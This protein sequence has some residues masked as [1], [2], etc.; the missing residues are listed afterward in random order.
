[1]FLK[2]VQFQ[3]LSDKLIKPNTMTRRRTRQ[4]RGR[5]AACAVQNMPPDPVSRSQ[6]STASD[7][8]TEED[9]V[10]V[11]TEGSLKPADAMDMQK[12]ST[13]PTEMA[14]ITEHSCHTE[15]KNSK[16]MEEQRDGN[17][18]IAVIAGEAT[19]LEGEGFPPETEQ[20]DKII[21]DEKMKDEM[22]DVSDSHIFVGDER[23]GK[24]LKVKKAVEEGICQSGKHLNMPSTTEEEAISHETDFSEE[25][26]K[27]EAQ[28]KTYFKEEKELAVQEI[29]D[30]EVEALDNKQVTGEGKEPDRSE[31]SLHRED[32]LTDRDEFSVCAFEREEKTCHTFDSS[33]VFEGDGDLD[34]GDVEEGDDDDE[35]GA[36]ILNSMEW[37][38]ELWKMKKA[39][40]AKA[41]GS[42]KVEN[43]DHDHQTSMDISNTEGESLVE[44]SNVLK[45]PEEC[46]EEMLEASMSDVKVKNEQKSTESVDD[47]DEVSVAQGVN[48]VKECSEADPQSMDKSKGSRKSADSTEALDFS[49]PSLGTLKYLASFPHIFSGPAFNKG[50]Q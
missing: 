41:R 18:D 47:E 43:S 16:E 23:L 21:E 39:E 36:D 25:A 7:D 10:P 6:D 42:D 26:G 49:G 40:E 48:T 14:K 3:D 29:N 8:H 1:M 34:D 15:E 11:E 44:T 27:V 46:D 50:E 5:A 22:P 38:E 20:V 24:N 33:E 37:V 30:D 2:C 17:S 32:S 19:M 45:I 12:G 35:D 31:V 9:K 13:D 4:S 28:S